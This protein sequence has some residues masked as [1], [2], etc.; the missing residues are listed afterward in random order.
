MKI[1]GKTQSRKSISQF[2]LYTDR[3]KDEAALEELLD[4]TNF[5]YLFK[6]IHDSLD[7]LETEA[8]PNSSVWV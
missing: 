6:A 1:M 8:C 3:R 4:S 7:H 2:K 5:Y